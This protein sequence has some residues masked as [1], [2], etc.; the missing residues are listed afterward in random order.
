MKT[1][2]D[3]YNSGMAEPFRRRSYLRITIDVGGTIY[4]FTDT[5]IVSASQTTDI[6]PLTRR[7]PKENF[8]FS[9]CDYVGAYNP[10]NPTGLWYALDENA[11]ITAQ[12]GFDLGGGETEWLAANEYLCD[13][14][15][16][17]K[18]GVATFK[19]SSRLCH[20]TK[21]YYKGVFGQHTLYELAEEVF[22]DAGYAAGEYSIDSSLQSM[23]TT[24]PLPI[25]SHQVCLQMIAHAARCTLRTDEN[26]VACIAPFSVLSPSSGVMI[27][28]DSIAL[29][30]DVVSKIE[31]LYKVQA[32]MYEYV[33][34][35]TASV[36]YEGT[37]DADGETVCHIEYKTSTAQ[38]IVVTGAVVT[39]T[40]FYA[41]AA[42]F[43]VHGSGTYTVLVTGK[44]V[45]S[46]VST[47][48]SVV[49]INTQGGTDVEK[50]ALIT[51]KSLQSSL[52]YHV[53]NYLQYRMTH[54]ITYRGNP[55]YE[56]LDA[57]VVQTQ[58]GDYISATVLTHTIK[59]N[60]A[61]SGT[62]TVKS[63]SEITDA[64]LYDS[65]HEQVYDSNG[66]SITVIDTQDYT[67]EY[68]TRQIDDFI[69]EVI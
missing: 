34:E 51:N 42:D 53:A 23:I 8:E 25:A 9:I 48:E 16:A 32:Q 29:N 40:H 11:P 33:A 20:L 47:A 24:A 68:T 12:F 44:A 30:G 5:D 60:G 66:D 7:L 26:N 10:A 52:I 21:T 27:G 56:P 65:N 49:S 64:Y 22:I 18:N 43:T 1:V 41:N 46:S 67:S 55:E 54:T 59:Y 28:L 57:L 15:P 35:A 38:S 61:L 39:D 13:G 63:L 14:K 62:M 69:T 2:S 50:N 58:Y 31:T 45:N 37:V 4:T 6:D 36:L 19:A 17:I 3:R